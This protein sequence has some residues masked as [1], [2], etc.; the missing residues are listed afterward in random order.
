MNNSLD[1][2]AQVISAR[3][4]VQPSQKGKSIMLSPSNTDNLLSI[5]TNK[6]FDFAEKTSILNTNSMNSTAIHDK[7]VFVE[8]FWYWNQFSSY[9]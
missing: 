6:I 2:D 7:D 1:D 5:Q 9:V 3:S 8:S 4:I